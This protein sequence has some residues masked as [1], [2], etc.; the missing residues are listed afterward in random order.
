MEV[1]FR[2]FEAT[3]FAGK[4]YRGIWN[5]ESLM[6]LAGE[7]EVEEGGGGGGGAGGMA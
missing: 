3:R 4:L 7:D 5:C 1:C 6:P 2:R